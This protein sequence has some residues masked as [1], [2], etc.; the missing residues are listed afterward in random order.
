MFTLN[1]TA[2]SLLVVAASVS[3]IAAPLPARA[4]SLNI[5]KLLVETA[6]M[7]NQNLPMMVD[8]NTRWDASFAGPGKT[9]SY[10]F[11][12][13]N[14]SAGKIDGVQ[15]ANDI[16]TSLTETVCNNSITKVFPENGVLLKFNY[17]DNASNLITRVNVAPNDC[18]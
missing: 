13:V 11:T 12:L 6:D 8:Q 10:K 17:Y 4:E 18:K 5:S 15:F 16:R 1:S 14:Y 9:L 3:A 2:K 7:M